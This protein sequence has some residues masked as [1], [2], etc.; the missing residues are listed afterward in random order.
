M[1]DDPYLALRARV[2]KGAA[3]RTLLDDML[4]GDVLEQVEHDAISQWRMARGPTALAT[5]EYSHAIVVGVDAIRGQLRMLVEDGT[6]AR[7]EI[8]DLDLTENV[9]EA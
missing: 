3:A 2:S 4:F 6:M 9:E 8:E 7:A 5:R 1:P